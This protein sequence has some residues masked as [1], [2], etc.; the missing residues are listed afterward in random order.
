MNDQLP[1]S[2]ETK[3][4][5]TMKTNLKLLLLLV[6]PGAMLTGSSL[7]QPTIINLGVFS[8]GSYS[9]AAGISADAT[10]VVG[11]GY[12]P[13]NLRPFR[14]TAGGGPQN[15]GTLAGYTYACSA[16]ATSSNGSVVVGSCQPDTT[17]GSGRAFRWTAASGMQSLGVLPNGNLSFAYA[18]NADGSIIVG[19][20]SDT[21]FRWTA[22]SGMQNLG[23]GSNSTANAISA[24]GSVIAGIMFVDGLQRAFRWTA[25]GGAQDLGLL[26]GTTEAQGLAISADGGTVTGFSRNSEDGTSRAF[27]WTADGGIQSLGA[28]VEGFVL[29]NGISADGSRIVGT[30]HSVGANNSRAFLWTAPLGMVDLN[31]YLPSRGVDLSEWTLT[32]AYGVSGD[33]TAIAGIGQFNGEARAFLVRGLIIAPSLNITRSNSVAILHWPV[34]SPNF[35]LQENMDLALPNAWSPV[36]QPAVTN[37]AQISVTVPAN[38]ARKFF[39]LKSQ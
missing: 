1:D 30:I 27:R 39:R 28:L 8:G 17:S 19:V 14:W 13:P 35:Q 16:S 9:A 32:S 2:N 37:D 15:L 6:V 3:L 34:S 10:T 7:A 23:L 4:K 24:D 11:Y 22:A 18:V 38:A 21:A 12:L 26:P 29:A 36:A 5:S 33:G 31:T 20:S 25:G